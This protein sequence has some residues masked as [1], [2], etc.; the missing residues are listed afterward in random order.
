MKAKKLL[1]IFLALALTT[2]ISF[3]TVPAWAQS[4]TTGDIA[5]TVQDPTGAVVP[6]AT[7]TLKNDS[8]GASSTT[9]T[10]GSGAYRFTLLQPGRYTVS[11]QQQ[12]FGTI[13]QTVQ[14]GVGQVTA[15][16]LQLQVGGASQTVEVTAAAPLLQTET[17][18]IATTFNTQQIENVPNPGNDMTFVAQTAP[19]VAI[20]SSSGGGYGNFTAFGLP[21][22][23][24][25]FTVNGNDEMDP[26]LNLNNS[27]ATNLLLG[28]N[29]VQE[30]AV[31]SNGYTGQ[32][33]RQAGAQVDY[34]TKSGTNDLHGNLKYWWNGRYLNANDWFANHSGAPRPF[35]NNNQYAASFGGP[36]KKD[37][38]FF[39]IGTE[40][41][42]YILGTS[43]QIFVPTPTFQAATLANLSTSG[44]ETTLGATRRNA[45][46]GPHYFNS[47][48]TLRKDFRVRERV[49][50]GIGATAYNV[51]NHANFANPAHDVGSTP[52]GVIQSTVV[53][54][55]SPYGAFVGSAV[56][57]R[58]LQLN[59]QVSF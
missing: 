58:L 32:Y 40:G 48:F 43:N 39:F 44:A 30:V 42:R 14:V 10:N 3:M 7:V 35:E 54:P 45:F 59:A 22:T 17:G 49:N 1:F 4:V 52:F 16:N 28:S 5:G 6:N 26:Y 57:G 15:A 23:S 33:G 38:A 19:G 29:E 55:T 50:F 24:N 20:N 47:D 27:G 36:I 31:V 9:R 41:L 56:S 8:T 51:F 2:A 37:K 21:A 53:P 18:N 34:V 12:G 13:N 11:V 25:L 46:R